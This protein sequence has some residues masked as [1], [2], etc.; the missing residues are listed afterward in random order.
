MP[1]HEHDWRVDPRVL[2]PGV[3]PAQRLV[4][5][6]CDEESSRP[7]ELESVSDAPV[8]WPEA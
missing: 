6:V 2:L 7:L 4:C 3:P 5:A 1:E 8:D